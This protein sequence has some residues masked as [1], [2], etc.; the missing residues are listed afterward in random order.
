MNVPEQ[1]ETARAMVRLTGSVTVL[2]DSS[3]FGRLT[4]FTIAGF[5]SIDCMVRDAAPG[6]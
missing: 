1:S 4:P 3:K 2:V 6:G 5:D